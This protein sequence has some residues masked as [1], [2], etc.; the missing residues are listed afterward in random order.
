[1]QVVLEF[2]ALLDGFCP[3]LAHLG[4]NLAQLGSNLGSTWPNLAQLG[5]TWPQ[6]GPQLLNLGASW[7]QDA[8]ETLPRCPPGPI[9]DQ[10]LMIFYCFNK[11]VI[12]FWLIFGWPVGL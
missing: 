11:V 2:E 10:M 7:G 8:S 4:A 9:L 1:M 12:D 3:N 6:L 5:P